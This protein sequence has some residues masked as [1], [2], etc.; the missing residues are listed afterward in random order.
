MIWY[1]EFA[2]ADPP[3]TLINSCTF[4]GNLHGGPT[5]IA[6]ASDEQKAPTSRPSSRARSCGARA[7]P[8][9]A[10]APTSVACRRKAEI[11][12]DELV[13]TG[14]KIWTSYAHVA[15]W[16]ELLVRT[17]P[18]APKH[19][20]ISWVICDMRSPGH[21]DPR[22]QDDEPRHRLLRGLLRRGPHPARQRRGRAEQRLAHRDVDPELR[23]RHGVHG[24]PGRHG[25]DGREA[26]RRGDDPHRPRRT[27]PAIADDEIAG[28][29][30]DRCGPRWRR[31]GR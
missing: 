14:Q 13:V 27:R 9:P 8:S 22:D 29:A 30:G 20:G 5:L 2:K 31:C 4:V 15:D 3:F 12:G 6:A 19:K 21:R 17:D 1:E 18:S 23:T 10:P 24:R 28:P 16:Q 25:V 7:S 11:D 26:D